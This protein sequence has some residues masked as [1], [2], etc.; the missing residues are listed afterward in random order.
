M[1]AEILLGIFQ[2]KLF[3]NGDAIIAYDRF[4][5]RVGWS[6]TPTAT[7]TPIA[8]RF[9]DFDGAFRISGFLNTRTTPSCLP[10]GA[11]RSRSAPL[12]G[13]QQVPRD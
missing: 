11:Y 3:G 8:Q 1:S 12:F 9:R 13:G 2:L 7:G 4:Y 6:S 5:R 10:R